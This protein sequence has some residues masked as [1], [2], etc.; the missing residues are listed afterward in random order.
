MTFQ[1]SF[2]EYLQ[3]AADRSFRSRVRLV[4]QKELKQEIVV[5][6]CRRAQI[7]NEVKDYFLF[8][9]QLIRLAETNVA[10]VWGS[11]TLGQPGE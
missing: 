3:S 7:L 9:E 1:E 10:T 5:G 8:A 6:E 2:E 11:R 4:K